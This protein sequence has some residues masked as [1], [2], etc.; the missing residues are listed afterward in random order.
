MMRF[1]RLLSGCLLVCF[2]MAS[3]NGQMTQRRLLQKRVTSIEASAASAAKARITIRLN[4]LQP[5]DFI[6]IRPGK[7]M[8]GS[9]GAIAKGTQP[10]PGLDAQRTF[11]MDALTAGDPLPDSS[12]EVTPDVITFT[13]PFSDSTIFLDIEIPAQ[14]SVR[15][16]VDGKSVLRASL[17]RPLAFRNKE[18]GEGALGIP[19]TAMRAALPTLG[20]NSAPLEPIYD[21]NTGSYIVPASRLSIRKRVP[22]NGASG[23]T[24]VVVLRIDAAG[25]VVKVSSLTDS[26]PPNLEEILSK[27]QFEPF[28]HNGVAVPVT[29][30]FRIVE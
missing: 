24:I 27:W 10:V 23:Q 20:T 21:R 18:W 28:I 14:C 30:V 16:V 17:R 29:A 22:V 8:V 6:N 12:L 9:A 13:R 7:Q 15:V 19:G 4:G 2:V 3:A 26:A 5:A 11:Q 1:L 25:R